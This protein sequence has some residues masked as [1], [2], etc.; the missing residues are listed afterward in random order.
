MLE[1]TAWYGILN[2][3]PS[4]WLNEMNT[5]NCLNYLIRSV[6]FGNKRQ[7]DI[8]MIINFTMNNLPFACV[9]FYFL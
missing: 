6:E 7:K 5:K 8:L 2:I 3:E 4:I 9:Q 1:I